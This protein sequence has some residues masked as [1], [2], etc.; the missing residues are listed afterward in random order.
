MGKK[1][2]KEKFNA[3][4]TT[5]EKYISDHNLNDLLK[6]LLKRKEK[7]RCGWEEIFESEFYNSFKKKIEKN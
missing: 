7:D 1:E 3:I 2:I 4:P 6:K 5:I